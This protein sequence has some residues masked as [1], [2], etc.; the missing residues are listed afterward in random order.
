M[1]LPILQTANA[2]LGRP[3]LGDGTFF[4]GE[5]QGDH[6]QREDPPKPDDIRLSSASLCRGEMP[7]FGN[8]SFYRIMG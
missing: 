4:C 8:T 6:V 2:I 5:T 1:V 3:S 7:S